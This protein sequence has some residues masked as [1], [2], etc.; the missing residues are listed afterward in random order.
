VGVWVVRALLFAFDIVFLSSLAVLI[1][2]IDEF[3]VLPITLVSI[4]VIVQAI[5]LRRFN[6]SQHRQWQ[7]PF[8]GLKATALSETKICKYCDRAISVSAEICR[9]C[10]TEVDEHP[11][12][13][14][15]LSQPELADLQLRTE[16]W[17]V[18]NANL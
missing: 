18:T 4:G 16:R 11:A 7:I 8:I 10:L 12:A 13:T 15:V 9:F 3:A 2:P 5:L 1:L 14:Q 17:L 6:L